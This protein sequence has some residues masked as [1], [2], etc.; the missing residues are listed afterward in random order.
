[1]SAIGPQFALAVPAVGAALIALTGRWP[2]L[3]ETV[4]LVTAAIL[5]L[6]VAS[7]LPAVMSGARPAVT[8]FTMLPGLGIGLLEEPHPSRDR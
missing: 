8:L 4:T 2:N 5:F 6:I 3:R 7:L 1:M